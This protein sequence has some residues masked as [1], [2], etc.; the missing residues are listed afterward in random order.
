MRLYCFIIF[1]SSVV[2]VIASYYS[3]YLGFTL[4][5][6]YDFFET[7]HL[8]GDSLIGIP[9]KNEIDELR[10]LWLSGCSAPFLNNIHRHYSH[11]AFLS[12]FG[13]S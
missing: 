2:L 6:Y 13:D 1:I 11:I 12:G 8:M 9:V 5:L 10:N 3:Y 4:L 7:F